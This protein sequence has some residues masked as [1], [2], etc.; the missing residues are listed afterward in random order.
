MIDNTI[1]MGI[2]APREH[3][4]VIT[5][6]IFELAYLYK[7]KLIPYFPYPETMIDASQTSPPP[8]IMLV[9]PETEL[10]QTIIEIT[11][12]QGVKKDLQKIQTLMREYGV[13]EGF[14]YDYKRRKWYRFSLEKGE[15]E[16]DNA[17]CVI[18]QR[19]LKEM[20]H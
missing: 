14:V 3:Q 1:F 18:I 20:I 8:D 9:D 10:T 6:L 13:P 17:F 11:H 12:S 5:Q 16:E 15:V 19:D 2:N 4:A 7:Q